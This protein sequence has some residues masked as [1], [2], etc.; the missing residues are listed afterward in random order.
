MPGAPDLVRQIVAGGALADPAWLVAFTEVP[1]ELFVPYYYVAVT[2]GGRERLWRDDPDPERRR[3][4][5][6][7]VYDDTPLATRVRDG[8]LVSSSSQPSLM[9]RMLDSLDVRDGMGVLEIGT[10]SGYNAAL[11]S[12][13]LGDAHVTSVDLDPGITTAAREHLAA[14]GYRPRVVTG[15]GALGVP[16]NAPYDRV[17]ATCAVPAVPAAWLAQCVRGALILAPVGTGLVALRVDGPGDG[18]GR[19]L[20]TPAFFVPLRGGAAPPS[21]PPSAPTSATR[22]GAADRTGERSGAGVLRGVPR[23]AQRQDSFH[24]L[25]GLVGG[26]LDPCDVYELWRCAGRPDRERYGLTVRD[27]VQWAWLDDP[28]GPHTW[29]LGG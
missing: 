10:G 4:W 19:F 20:P 26:P 29:P 14:A 28:D 7:G 3:R 22:S 1:R 9:A 25:F 2:G 13:R 24:F 11:L 5:L 21:A 23:H 27:G 16:A 6:E 17:I 12:H 8:E 15:D 18:E